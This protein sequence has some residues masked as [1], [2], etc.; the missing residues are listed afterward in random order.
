MDSSFHLKPPLGLLGPRTWDSTPKSALTQVTAVKTLIAVR[1]IDETA[2]ISYQLS[3]IR[4]QLSEGIVPTRNLVK[5]YSDDSSILVSAM[6]W[7]LKAD[8]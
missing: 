5:G 8:C 2:L 4:Y 6:S 3:G 7:R 1:F